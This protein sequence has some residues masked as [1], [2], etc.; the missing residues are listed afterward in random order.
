MSVAGQFPGV[1]SVNSAVA[2]SGKGIAASIAS[3]IP[4]L[5]T[6]LSAKEKKIWAHVTGA[7]LEYGLIHRTDGLTISIICRTYV[8]WV[9]ATEELSRYKADN[10]GTY[11]TESANG[12]R[13]PHPLYYVVRDHKKSLLD[14]LPEAALTIPSFH[15]IKGD[16]VELPQGDLFADPI[17]AHKQRKAAIGMRLV[18]D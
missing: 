14:W 13:Q 10:A 5:P 9:E 12:Y 4:D 2:D 6:K 1:P 3:E 18:K 15:K 11:I 17:E 7:L 8:D 16:Q